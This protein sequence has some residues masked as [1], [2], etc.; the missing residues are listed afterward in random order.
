MACYGHTLAVCE[1]LK[2]FYFLICELKENSLCT[3]SFYEEKPVMDL[4]KN[5]WLLFTYKQC[6]N[7]VVL[8]ERNFLGLKQ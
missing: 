3:F 1:F 5:I 7:K 6:A 8:K 4:S 2:T